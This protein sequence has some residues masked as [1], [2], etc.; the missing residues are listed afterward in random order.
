MNVAGRRATRHGSCPALAAA[1]RVQ[2]REA[3]Y[4]ATFSGINVTK[5]AAPVMLFV[6]VRKAVSSGGQPRDPRLD[7]CKT[8][9]SFLELV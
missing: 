4:H 5:L 9:D 7:S 6:F 1:P 8:L 3:P 2:M